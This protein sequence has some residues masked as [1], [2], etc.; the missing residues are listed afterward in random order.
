MTKTKRTAKFWL[1]LA[2]VLCFISALGASVIQTN[3]GKVTVKDL[4]FM[5]QAGHE[6]SALLFV[7]DTATAENPAPAIICSHGWYN[8]REMQDLNFVEYARRGFVVLAIDMYGHGNSDD[9]PNGQWLNPENNA[10][11]MYDAVQMMSRLDFVDRDRIGVTGHSN[12]ALASRVAVQLDNLAEEPL[13]AAALLVSND[14]EYQNADGEFYNMFGARDAA[15]VAC[16]YDEFF[17][18]VPQAD[19]SYSAPREYIHQATAQ[20]FLHFGQDP[21]GLEPRES[22]HLYHEDIDGQDAIRAV[23]NPAIIHPWAH[24]SGGVVASSL[25]FFDAALGAPN[26]IA[27]TNQIWQWK[28]AFNAL[29]LIGFMIFVV[30]LTKVLLDTRAFAAL[31]AGTEIAPKPALTGKARSWFWISGLLATVFSFIVYMFG[32]LPINL[33]MPSFMPQQPP[34]FIGMWSAA[35]GLFALLLIWIGGKV[36]GEKADHAANGVRIGAKK[37]LHTVVLAVVV[38][39]AAYTLVFAADYFF[40]TDFRLWVLPLKAF[41][42]DKLPIVLLY[43]PL[44]LAYYI[45]NSISINSY[46]DFETKRSWMNISLNAMFNALASVIM[47]AVMY[48]VFRVTGKLPNEFVPIFGGSILGIWLFPVIVILPVAAVVSRKLYRVTG[49]PYLAG[50]IMALLVTIMSCTN[51]LTVAL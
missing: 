51:T 50:I 2:L 26:P 4:R 22:Y 47:V 31:K 3:F 41:D 37:L 8:T 44:F 30:S 40:H 9:L 13:I 5:G 36:T 7:P 20:S 10:N 18:R 29:G 27:P 45:P 6:M 14:A 11:G 49:N 33:M 32:S 35:C 43:L 25:E 1:S 39:A 42:A 12:G 38:V 28:A 21:S 16:Q 23:F 17:H 34:F 46:N 48:T 24:F 19:G 15:I